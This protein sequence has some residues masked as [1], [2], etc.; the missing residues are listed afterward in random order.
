MYVPSHSKL[1]HQLRSALNIRS[2]FPGQH[3]P[4]PDFVGDDSKEHANEE[5]RDGEDYAPIPEEICILLRD[6]VTSIRGHLALARKE[7]EATWSV[8][9]LRAD[10]S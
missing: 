10:C 8:F 3:W 4:A 6:P 9:V 7:A 5:D 2:D 1:I